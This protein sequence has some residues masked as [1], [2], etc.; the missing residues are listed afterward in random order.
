MSQPISPRVWERLACSS[1]G[2]ALREERNGAE[3]PACHRRYA[4]TGSGA[5]DLRLQQPREYPLVFQ[6]GAA[7]LPQTGSLFAPLRMH[8]APEVRYR[9][10]DVPRHLTPEI[11][12]YFPKAK[13]DC[14]LMLDLGCGGGIHKAVCEQAGYEWVGL[15]YD[16]SGAQILGDAQALP[17]LDETFEFVLCVTVL[18]YIRY[19]FVMAREVQRVLKPGGKLI[20]TVAFLE[21]SHGT[22]FYHHTHLGTLNS[23]QSA[24]LTVERVAPS[25]RWS[26][27]RALANMGL[28][29]RM[30]D[31]VSEAIVMPLQALHQLWWKLGGWMTRRD[32]RDVRLRNF[33]GSFTFIASKDASG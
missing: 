31:A 23:L 33:T 14:S 27:L 26:V 29:Y 1:C 10:Q 4:F 16:S 24:G 3:C 30:P 21:P 15:D 9:V 20:G 18:Q 7:G 25:E 2:H 17:F 12:S 28:F 32:L 5:L 19:P 13:S 22:S 6:L 8:P 11:L